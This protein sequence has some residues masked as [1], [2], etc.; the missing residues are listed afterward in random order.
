VI[1]GHA[2]YN[3]LKFKGFYASAV[4]GSG[5]FSVLGSQEVHFR[6]LENYSLLPALLPKIVKADLLLQ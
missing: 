2:V 1:D 5:K 3:L 4:S 6:E